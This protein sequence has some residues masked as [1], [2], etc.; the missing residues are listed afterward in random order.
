M[1]AS[2]Q[3]KKMARKAAGT[4]ASAPPASPRPNGHRRPGPA[5]PTSAAPSSSTGRSTAR[6]SRR[7]RRGGRLSGCGRHGGALREHRRAGP[8]PAGREHEHVQRADRPATSRPSMKS[9]SLLGLVL[10]LRALQDA[11]ELHLAEAAVGE[12]RRGRLGRLGV[13]GVDDLGRRAG[14]VADDERLG[15][16]AGRAGEV[17]GVGLG[18]AVDDLDA[19]GPEVRPVVAASRPRRTGRRGQEERQAGRGVAGFSTTSRSLY[20][21][22]VRSSSVDGGVRPL[23][24]EPLLVVVDAD[25]AVV[26][27]GDLVAGHE[28]RSVAGHAGQRGRGVRRRRSR[29]RRPARAACCR[30]PRARRP[31]ACPWSARRR[32]TS[33]PA[34]PASAVFTLMPVWAVNWSRVAGLMTNE[35]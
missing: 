31:A 35:S 24:D 27:R 26:D 32:L 23:V 15:A 2:G 17:G 9:M 29:R 16:L 7:C 5:R 3:T 34:S 6:G 18:P 19:V 14:R 21:G 10:V 22:L 1:L 28:A 33:W 13:G 8:R 20:A 12:R 11:G 4:A 25:V 30:R